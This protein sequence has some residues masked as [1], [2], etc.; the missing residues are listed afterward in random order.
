MSNYLFPVIIIPTENKAKLEAD[1][2]GSSFPSLLIG[3]IGVAS[4]QQRA[5]VLKLFNRP[6]PFCG[7]TVLPG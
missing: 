1:K 3:E 6:T 5:Y 4:H 2:G 7:E